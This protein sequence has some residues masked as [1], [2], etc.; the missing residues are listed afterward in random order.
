MQSTHTMAPIPRLSTRG[1]AHRVSVK[2][3]S[4]QSKVKGPGFPVSGRRLID[5]TASHAT[6]PSDLPE[7]QEHGNKAAAVGPGARPF[8]QH[9]RG[10]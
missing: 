1:A 8:E 6:G 4:Y 3:L 2:S 7:V 9:R 10:L 5:M